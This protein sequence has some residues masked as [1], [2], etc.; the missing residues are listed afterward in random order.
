MYTW[1]GPPSVA[2]IW[3]ILI[4]GDDAAGALTVRPFEY[5]SCRSNRV[6]LRQVIANPHA[7]QICYVGGAQ[8][9]VDSSP[10]MVLSADGNVRLESGESELD[11][12]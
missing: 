5:C 4:H 12:S 11:D 7:A 1:P 9:F 2:D 8:G 6:Q 10:R 3:S